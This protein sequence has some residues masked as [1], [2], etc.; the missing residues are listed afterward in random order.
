M[1]SVEDSSLVASPFV[2]FGVQQFY[3]PWDLLE[4][5]APISINFVSTENLISNL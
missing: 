2:Y 5:H 4:I 3:D 1:I